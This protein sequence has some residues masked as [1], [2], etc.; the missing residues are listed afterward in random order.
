M[1][2]PGV[3]T[4]KPRVNRGLVGCRT[5]LTVC[6]AMS[7]AMTVV[8]PAPVASFSA[9]RCR[10]GFARSF[11]DRRR[12]RKRRPVAD[13]GATSVS[14]IAVST[15]STWQKK[16]RMPAVE[17]WRQWCR[18]RAGLR[19]DLPLV[20]WQLAPSIDD[21][22]QVVDDRR[23]VVLLPVGLKLLR[24]LVEHELALAA[25]LPRGGNRRD[26]RD[27]ATLIE[28]PVRGLSGSRPVPSDGVGYS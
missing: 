10:P 20:R 2:R 18:R 5:A 13:L 24:L 8:L 22:P 23:R 12:S 1:V 6:H 7:M 9:T 11:A 3:T 28:D 16:G 25:P 4:R 21:P 19:R 27:A 17:W 14:Q 15:A 26:Q